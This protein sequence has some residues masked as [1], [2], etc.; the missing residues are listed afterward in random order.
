VRTL[1]AAIVRDDQPGARTA[2]LTALQCW[3]R[4]GAAYGSFGSFA[5]AIDGLPSGRPGGTG[6]PGF[7][8]LHRVEY[9]LWHGEPRTRLLSSVD[10]LGLDVRALRAGLT[11]ALPD[12]RDL[13]LRVQEVLEDAARFDLEGLT[14]LG[15]GAGLAETGAGV[16]ATEAL[17]DVFGPLLDVRRPG[18]TPAARTALAALRR[19]LLTARHGTGWPATSSLDPDTRRGIESALGAALEI[20]A[21]APGL[22]ET[23]GS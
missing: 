22:L 23:A 17:L 9:G 15:G 11:P 12:A 10:R 8:G 21:Q 5:D 14:D 16:D 19:A 18:L 6:D 2:W 3:A 1:R 20:L 13:P 4:V 7:T